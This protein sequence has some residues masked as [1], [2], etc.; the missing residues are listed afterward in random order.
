MSPHHGRESRPH[1]TETTINATPAD[2]R[3][4]SCRPTSPATSRIGTRMSNG[5]GSTCTK[6][7]DTAVAQ[8]KDS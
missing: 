6:A 8:R 2:H 5:A 7:S 1:A 4:R 3:G